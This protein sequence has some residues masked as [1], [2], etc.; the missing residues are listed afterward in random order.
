[1]SAKGGTALRM[2]LALE[3]FVRLGETSSESVQG[4]SYPKPPSF[5]SPFTGV[6]PAL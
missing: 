4:S 5:P 1:M 3:L 6:N 2:I